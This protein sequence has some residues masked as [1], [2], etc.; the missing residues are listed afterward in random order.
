MWPPEGELCAPR[1]EMCAPEGGGICTSLLH[2]YTPHTQ[3]TTEWLCV[4]NPDI[5]TVLSVGGIMH[6]R[7]VGCWVED[8]YNIMLASLD[9][10][11]KLLGYMS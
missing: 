5:A 11:R 9:G 1:G 4:C 7:T 8:S 2:W 10:V 6:E 3:H